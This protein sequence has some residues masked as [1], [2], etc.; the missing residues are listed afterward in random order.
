MV[1]ASNGENSGIAPTREQD[2]RGQS[3]PSTR[4]EKGANYERV[5][6]NEGDISLLRRSRAW[7]G[8]IVISRVEANSE[9]TF[10]DRLSLLRT[11]SL[12]LVPARGC[13]PAW[14]RPTRA[15]V[16]SASG[17]APSRRRAQ[18]VSSQRGKQGSP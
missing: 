16:P 6:V 13:A 3:P 14:T 10:I 2:T 18:M 5:G 12:H 17:V 11:Y 4:T 1:V 15:S 7:Y 9:T 8:G